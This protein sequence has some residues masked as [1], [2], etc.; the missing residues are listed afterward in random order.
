[1]RRFK[2]KIL[3]VDDSLMQATVLKGMLEEQ[4]DIII[5]TGGQACL[6][7]LAQL[8]YKVDLI[9]LDVVMPEIDGFEVLRRRQANPKFAEVPVIVLTMSEMEQDQV[10]TFEL[11]ANDFILKPAK[12]EI[13]LF[14]INNVLSPRR[15]LREI[16]QEKEK[17]K[18]KA[19][20]DGM[21]SLYNK[22]TTE[23]L[24]N[25]ILEDRENNH[26][27]LVI[28]VDNFKAVNDNLGHK[29]GDHTI[30]VIA[31]VIVGQFRK[32][33]IVGRFGGDEFVVLMKNVTDKDAPRRL[34]NRIIDIVNKR[35]NLTIP[36]F[37]SVSIGIACS[38]NEVVTMDEL[39]KRAD[40]ALYV[41]KKAGK[42]RATEYGKE[43]EVV[44]DEEMQVVAVQS[45]SRNNTS[46]L[47]S[48]FGN[49]ARTIVS[50]D[51][52]ELLA[53]MYQVPEDLL[54]AICVDVS[55]SEDDGI[56]QWKK[57]R[58][59]ESYNHLP[60]IAICQEGNLHQMKLA[61]NSGVISDLIF[62]PIEREVL[63]RRFE[64][65]VK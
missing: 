48:G 18:E 55:E 52:D 37:V 1:M 60:I 25:E 56:G 21:T 22:A 49:K 40:S 23:T 43:D 30:S 8:D 12:K 29:T 16:R 33:D 24:I 13:A 51:V 39:F 63:K 64:V 65:I 53:L 14:R 4:F 59:V 2:E 62:A 58:E 3:V 44:S 5:A 26:A 11:G 35:T 47:S 27:L 61:L 54:L 10:R 9:L 19:E 45:N 50:E 7:I 32:S 31:G 38:N 46:T 17:F 6:D 42:A 34:A 41:S 57:W 36:D 20:V 28:D 15:R